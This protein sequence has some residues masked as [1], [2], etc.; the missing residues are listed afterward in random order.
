MMNEHGEQIDDVPP[1]FRVE[2][3]GLGRAPS[4]GDDLN[5]VDDEQAAA[6]VA[7]HRL[8]KQ[9]EGL[10]KSNKLTIEDILAKGKKTRKGPQGDRQGGRARLREPTTS[11][12]TRRQHHRSSVTL[13]T[14]E[15]ITSTDTWRGQLRSRVFRAHGAVHVRLDDSP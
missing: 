9:R 11:P 6:V 8:K 10:S 12:G 15:W 5:V 13:P 1:G 3:L 7:E 4:A 14:A 2:V